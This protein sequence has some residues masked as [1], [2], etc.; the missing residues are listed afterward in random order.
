MSYDHHL[1]WLNLN[2]KS[3]SEYF[4]SRGFKKF[5]ISSRDFNARIL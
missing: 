1:N 4:D 2:D 5:D 3:V